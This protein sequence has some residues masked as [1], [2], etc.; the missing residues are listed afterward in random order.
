[1]DT[2]GVNQGGNASD[3]LF[4]RYL[5]DPLEYL[6]SA[7]GICCENKAICHL[8]WADDLIIISD[9]ATGLQRQLDGLAKFCAKNRMIANNLK[10]KAMKFGR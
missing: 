1:M 7:F 5:A 3:L 9:S 4:R 2:S 6:D 8:M 10:T